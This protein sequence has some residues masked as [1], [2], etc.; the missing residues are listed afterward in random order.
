MESAQ[1]LARV[2]DLEKKIDE[3]RDL[4]IILNDQLAGRG[5]V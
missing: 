4:L 1:I 3:I 5:D 2:N